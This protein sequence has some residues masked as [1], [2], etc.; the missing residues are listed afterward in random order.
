MP[1]MTPGTPMASRATDDLVSP[2]RKL[3]T[4][5]L[6][7]GAL[8]G[9]VLFAMQ[10]FT[11]VPLIEAAERSEKDVDHHRT[12][13]KP[14]DK[15][16]RTAWTVATTVLSSI[17]FA[18]VLFG[19]LSLSGRNIS[20]RQG[21]RWG[22]AAFVCFHLAPSFGLPPLPPGVPVA[23]VQQRQLW[24]VFAVLATAGGLWLIG[25]RTWMHRVAGAV[26]V[27]VPHVIGAPVAVGENTIPVELVRNFA[28]ASL[29]T[30]AIFWPL[31][32]AIGGY[33]SSRDAH[34][35]SPV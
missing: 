17:G 12:E 6:C 16:E 20:M 26:C 35:R 8:A 14:A 19:F 5:V 1:R 30:A 28:V 27:A 33:L 21:V 22:L 32:G 15:S 4:V 23:E 7:S 9:L 25:R 2:F 24:W 3:M 13:W 34:Q 31:L 18:A 11:V 29:A 10:H